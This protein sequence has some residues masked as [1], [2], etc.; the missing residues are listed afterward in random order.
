MV[1]VE[2]DAV[3]AERVGELHLVEILVIELGA[4]LRIVVAVGIGDPG[5]AVLLDRVE[6]GVAIGHEVEVE[7]FHAAFLIS[8]YTRVFDALCRR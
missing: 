7:E 6:V 4:L 3:E 8:A 1:L 2:A 5:G